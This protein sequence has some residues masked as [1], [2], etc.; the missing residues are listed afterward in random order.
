MGLSLSLANAN[1]DSGGAGRSEDLGT[2]S[3]N[4]ESFQEGSWSSS[5]LLGGAMDLRGKPGHPDHDLALSAIQTA[6]NFSG[7][8]G[9]SAWY[10]GYWQFGGELLG[11]AQPGND[12]KYLAGILPLLTYNFVTDSRL[13]P[14]VEGGGG[15]AVTDIGLPDLSTTF[16]FVEQGGIGL[17]W[18][19]QDTLGL[20]LS[21]GI[22]HI[23][24]GGIK[25]PNS[26][27]TVANLMLG[28]QWNY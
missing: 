20:K 5:F 7:L 4:L 8:L 14:Y 17:R 22:I 3:A 15:I 21:A 19:F 10:R 23:S 1:A 13:I 28:L 16:E 9:E 27:V 25:E 26:G 11:G 12:P 2:S 24:N 6:Y 18:Q